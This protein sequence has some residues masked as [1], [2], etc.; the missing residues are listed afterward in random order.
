[1][2]EINES[3]GSGVAPEIENT[4]ETPDEVVELDE[5][6]E[7]T[8]EVDY[9]AELAKVKRET[10]VRMGKK[11]DIANAERVRE[12]AARIEAE[13]NQGLPP[14]EV[15]QILEKRLA[16]SEARLS[17]SFERRLNETKAR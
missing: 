8:P 9:E 14:E 16:D 4:A 13:K 3:V 15:E 6:A 2:P 1:M 11:I 5:G 7:A 10:E 12:R 17:A